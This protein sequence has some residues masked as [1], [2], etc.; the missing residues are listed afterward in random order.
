[1]KKKLVLLRS[2]LRHYKL[3][4]E[5]HLRTWIHRKNCSWYLSAHS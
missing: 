3:Y 1:M 5:Y 4:G 2:H